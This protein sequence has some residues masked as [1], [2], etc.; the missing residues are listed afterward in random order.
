MSALIACSALTSFVFCRSSS[1][2]E[3]APRAVGK[4]PPRPSPLKKLRTLKEA[5]SRL[6]F[7]LRA[8]RAPPVSGPVKSSASTSVHVP[9]EGLVAS[10][11]I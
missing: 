3:L 9:V 11:L 5:T 4:P 8:P 7:P 10:V 1:S 2:C 6:P